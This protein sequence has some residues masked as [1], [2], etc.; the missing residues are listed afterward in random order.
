MSWD[1]ESELEG[2]NTECAPLVGSSTGFALKIDNEPWAL[3]LNPT[4]LSNREGFLSDLASR[5]CFG[6]DD[7]LDVVATRTHTGTRTTQ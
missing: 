2:R 5:W 7:N 3:G 4:D 1:G 6:L